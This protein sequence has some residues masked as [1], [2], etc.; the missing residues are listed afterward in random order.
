MIADTF[1]EE[2]EI[3]SRPARENPTMSSQVWDLDVDNMGNIWF[4]DEIQNALWRFSNDTKSFEMI[5]VPE[6]LP[7]SV[8]GGR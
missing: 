6:K 2:Y 1:G 3:P 8:Y 4:T 7:Y 5:A